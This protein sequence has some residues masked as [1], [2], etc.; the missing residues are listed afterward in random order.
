MDAA[1]RVVIVGGG[2]GGLYAAQALRKARVQVTLIDRRNFHLFQP[3]L[4]QVA[5]GGLS[6]ANIASPLRAVLRRHRNATVL[7]GEV[8]DF[9]LDRREVILADGRLGYD[10]LIV[11]TG[12]SHH[13]FGH[14]EWEKYAPGL[15]TIEDATTIRRR[16]LT[17]FEQAERSDDPAL[18]RALLTFVVVGGGPTGVELAGAVGDMAHYTLRGNFRRINPA[19]ARIYLVEA[20][21][22]ILPSY[23][24]DLSA[25]AIRDLERLGV[26]VMTGTAVTD[27]AANRVTVRRGEATEVIEAHTVLWGA[28]VQA[29]PLAKLLADRSGAPIDRAGRVHI[30]PDCCLPGHPEVFVIGDMAHYMHQT[31]T[32]LP[33][34]AQVA[35]QM[36]RYAASTI[37]ARVEGRTPPGP[38]HYKDPGSMAT[39]G[40]AA[41]VVDMGW[42]HLKGYIGWWAWLFVH[43][44]YLIAFENR[45]LV[46]WQWAWSYFTR[47]RSARLITGDPATPGPPPS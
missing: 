37:R 16:V 11:A 44:L 28:G 43:L 2:F 29:S 14:A 27:I 39:I 3:L 18:Q 7:L 23:P 35:M 5:T 38:F 26:T 1:H 31:G 15:K 4:Y 30:G 41:A 8:V 42:L 47:G 17:A 33:G 12:A 45:V 20:G 22:R 21:P 10:S 6:P 25:R 46:M 24:P 9:D 40:H 34:V 19:T 36:G 13:Y 32:P